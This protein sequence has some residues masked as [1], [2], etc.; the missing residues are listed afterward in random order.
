MENLDVI[1]TCCEKIEN[2]RQKINNLYQ[3]KDY[4]DVM[5]RAEEICKVH[6]ELEF[7]VAVLKAVIKIIDSKKV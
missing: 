3:N 1:L 2:L 5:Q 4:E 6:N 7:E